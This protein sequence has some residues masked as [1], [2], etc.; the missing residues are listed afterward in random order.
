MQIARESIFVSS[1]RGFFRCFFSVF[2]I[3][4]GLLVASFLYSMLSS[5]PIHEEKTELSFLPDLEGQ[6]KMLPTTAPAILQ[7]DLHGVIGD[8][9]GIQ[10]EDIKQILMSSRTGLLSNDRVKGILLHIDTPGGEVTASDNIYQ[11]IKSY[12][13]KYHVPVFAFVN[14]LCASG[15]MYISSSTDQIFASPTSIIGSIGVI[16]GPFFNVADTMAKLGV[17][18]K[19][20]TAGLDKDMMSPFR[21]WKPEEDASLKAIL[22]SMYNRFVDIVTANRPHVDKTKLVNEYGAHVFDV[23]K[24]QEIGYIDQ[25]NATYEQALAALLETAQIDPTKPYQVVELK[26]VQN[27]LKALVESKSS[28]LKGTIEHTFNWTNQPS[29]KLHDPFLYLYQPGQTF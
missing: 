2:G 14:G 22:A 19:T 3:V 7:I 24:A 21:T 20:L 17:A 23:V 6:S 16:I 11:L 4:F 29:Y 12:K 13:E 18:S 26:P 15:G 28:V 10:A 27:W 8:L 1:L 5:A 9:H 25:A